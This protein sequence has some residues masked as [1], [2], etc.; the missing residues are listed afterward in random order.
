MN[1]RKPWTTHEV[2]YLQTHYPQ[3]SQL[4]IAMQLRRSLD[5]IRWKVQE[6]GLKTDH[7]QCWTM[8]EIR[9]LEA[10]HGKRSYREM[11][12]ALGRGI[13]SVRS[14]C[15]RLDRAMIS[16]QWSKKTPCL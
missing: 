7:R 12:E 10:N 13:N 5:S 15:N 3:R 16:P 4:Q 9:Y 8:K 6:L 1:E 11:A 2:R 14:M